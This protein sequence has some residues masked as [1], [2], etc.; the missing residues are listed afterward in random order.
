MATVDYPAS[1]GP[2][3]VDYAEGTNFSYTENGQS[4]FFSY[5]GGHI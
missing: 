1:C 4:V 5:N 2:G 3:V